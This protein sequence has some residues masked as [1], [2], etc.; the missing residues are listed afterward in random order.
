MPLT[1]S[2]HSYSG[3][4]RSEDFIGPELTIFVGS[5]RS[6]RRGNFVRACVRPSLSSNNE[7]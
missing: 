4:I 3:I 6:P 5:D 1:N 2:D 7:F